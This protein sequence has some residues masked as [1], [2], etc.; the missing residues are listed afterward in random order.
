MIFFRKINKQNGRHGI[1]D[2]AELQTQNRC[3]IVPDRFGD[4]KDQERRDMKHR[5]IK[6][7]ERSDDV[8]KKAIKKASDGKKTECGKNRYA[9]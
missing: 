1:A 2:N 5:F 3:G 9:S 4:K 7:G 6:H 8:N